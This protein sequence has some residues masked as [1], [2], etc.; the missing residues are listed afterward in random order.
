[1]PKVESPTPPA[2]SPAPIVPA[3]LVSGLVTSAPKPLAP[4]PNAAIPGTNFRIIER[5][6]RKAVILVFGDGGTGKTTLGLRFTPQPAVLIG[7]DGRSEYVEEQ[8][9]LAGRPI[10]AVQ[11]APPSVIQKS[12]NVRAAAREALAEFF[13]NYDGAI[14][15]SLNGLVRTIVID[16]ASELGEIINLSV[17]GSLDNRN[18]DYGRSKDQ[19]NQI[20]WKIFGAAR[21]TGKAHVVFLARASSIWEGNQ[22]TGDFRAR[23]VDAVRDGVDFSLH[24]RLGNGVPAAGLVAPGGVT[25]PVVAGPALVG[26]LTAVPVPSVAGVVRGPKEFEL[27]VRKSGNTNPIEDVGLVF[28]ESDWGEIG[29]FA[30]ACSRLMPGST[31]DDWR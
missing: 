3:G 7:F 5:P 8:M 23:V 9:K 12:D 16:T 10:P 29:P 31:V 15:A 6:K 2:A 21:F 28:R 22:P 27:V 4:S 11:I 14:A 19:I 20:W 30:Y 24:I 17:R 25:G 18:D 26:G 13:L 1:M